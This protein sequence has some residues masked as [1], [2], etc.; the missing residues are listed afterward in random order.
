MDV[1]SAGERRVWQHVKLRRIF[2]QR[3]PSLLLSLRPETHL[4]DSNLFPSDRP[5]TVKIA[6]EGRNQGVC[7]LVWRRG[8][9]C[10]GSTCICFSSLGICLQFSFWQACL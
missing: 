9:P 8:S 2:C 10:A 7:L 1:A 6:G 5:V 3:A 4:C